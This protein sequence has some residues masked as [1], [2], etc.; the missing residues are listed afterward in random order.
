[1]DNEYFVNDVQKKFY[2]CNKCNLITTVIDNN[3][4]IKCNICKNTMEEYKE[5]LS[6]TQAYDYAT[7]SC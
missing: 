2:V 5:N 4:S 6:Y 3:T 1:M 7:V